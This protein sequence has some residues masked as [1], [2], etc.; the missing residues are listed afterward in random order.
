MSSLS[1]SLVGMGSPWGIKTPPLV[2]PVGPTHLTL[3]DLS[4]GLRRAG[5]WAYS[6]WSDESRRSRR[7]LAAAAP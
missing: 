6:C 5:V 4:P 2:C 3:H 7:E 1:I